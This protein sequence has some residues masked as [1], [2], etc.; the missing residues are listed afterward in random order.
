M[1]A[2]EAISAALASDSPETALS[3][4]LQS[5]LSSDDPSSFTA[6]F[7]YFATDRTSSS[8]LGS[9]LRTLIQT[10]GDLPS[11]SK[12][13]DFWGALFPYMNAL[14]S[15]A[16][17]SAALS[18][19]YRA[20]CT[21]AGRFQEL[22]LHL[23][24][25]PFD[26]SVSDSSQTVDY[27]TSIAEAW[28]DARVPN[29]PDLANAYQRAAQNFFPLSTPA[30]LVLRFRKVRAVYW[31]ENSDYI[32]AT[33]EYVSIANS[34]GRDQE[35]PYI[36]L[37]IVYALLASG[38]ARGLSLMAELS[39]DERVW[40]DPLSRLLKRFLEKS[41]IGADEVTTFSNELKAERGFSDETL[42]KSVLS[43]NLQTIASLY[44]SIKYSTLVQFLGA[45]WDV[46]L[47]VLKELIA[48]KLFKGVIDQ[49][50][51]IVRFKLYTSRIDIRDAKIDAFGRA[52]QELTREINTA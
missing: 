4:V 33:R 40:R 29:S 9:T 3:S 37:A 46:I 19:R 10:I 23:Q 1:T 28:I 11:D 14:S 6:A 48:K 2:P 15:L 22:A 20:A 39:S 5:Y 34:V 7:S 49:P 21:S 30:P 50:K 41:L 27:W 45:P 31:I 51:E 47:P 26:E 16:A 8:L 12:R 25:I 35:G 44:K 17:E 36:H 24:S 13:V 38:D 18:T 52:V 43:H 32:K 42:S